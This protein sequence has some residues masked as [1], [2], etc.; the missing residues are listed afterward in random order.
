ML[1]RANRA[2]YGVS[3]ATARDSH[4]YAYVERSTHDFEVVEERL[5]KFLQRET[6]FVLIIS[7]SERFFPLF[8]PQAGKRNNFATRFPS[9]ISL[10][11]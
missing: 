8:P 3:R 4:I 5:K 1:S 10:D 11:P 6:H 2:N 7:F 9:I